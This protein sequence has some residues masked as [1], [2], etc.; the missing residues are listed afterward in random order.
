MLMVLEEMGEGEA[1]LCAVQRTGW[2]KCS[3]SSWRE[4][5]APCSDSEISSSLVAS[6]VSPPTRNLSFGLGTPPSDRQSNL[7]LVLENV[8]KYWKI[9][10][11]KLKIFENI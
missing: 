9:L 8:R 3:S 6:T 4:R 10:E 7:L 2:L 11:I 1:L 5:T